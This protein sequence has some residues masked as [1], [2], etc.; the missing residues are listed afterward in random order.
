MTTGPSS[1]IKPIG[2]EEII[3]HENS[4]DCNMVSEEN[5]ID[6]DAGCEYLY[7]VGTNEVMDQEKT[8]P[9]EIVEYD[10][11]NLSTE[12]NTVDV[13]CTEEKVIDFYDND[14]LSIMVSTIDA[15]YT[16][17]K[18]T[19]EETGYASLEK[20]KIDKEQGSAESNKSIAELL[21]AADSDCINPANGCEYIACQSCDRVFHGKCFNVSDSQDK[22]LCSICAGVSGMNEC[23]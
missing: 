15:P 19:A 5:Q 17:K 4:G 20:N 23:L 7:F 8:E 12:H 6:Q 10:R 16:E 3:V 2:D 22:I 1:T 14:S 9:N 13:L 11:E 21:C 18:Y